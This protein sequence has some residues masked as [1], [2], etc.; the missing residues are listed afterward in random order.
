MTAAQWIAAAKVLATAIDLFERYAGGDKKLKAALA[1]L[2][3]LRDAV[4]KG[5]I[6]KLGVIDADAEVAKLVELMTSNNA[7]HRAAL[8]KRFAK[9]ETP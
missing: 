8:K 9:E 6:S 5:D 1:K 4:K 3:E 7:K 2:K